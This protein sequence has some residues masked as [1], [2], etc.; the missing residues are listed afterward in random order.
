[1]TT[2]EEAT[3]NHPG[4]E[5]SKPSAQRETR[6]YSTGAE[7]DAFASLTLLVA[8]LN[9]S[10]TAFFKYPKPSVAKEDN[11]TYENRPLGVNKLG[12]VM[13]II[14]VGAELSQI[15]TNHSVRESVIALLSDANVPDP[16]IM[17]VSGHSSE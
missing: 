10:C 5:N 3:K 8:Q 13:K 12:D 7:D 14:S 11:V 4:G 6:L 2:H 1:M 9:L 15:Y 17:V 16:H